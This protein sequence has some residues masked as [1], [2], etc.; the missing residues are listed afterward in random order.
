MWCIPT[1]LNKYLYCILLT[2]WKVKWLVYAMESLCL[3][4]LSTLCNFYTIFILFCYFNRTS[5]PKINFHL[6]GP[7]KHE[8]VLITHFFHSLWFGI[9]LW[10]VLFVV[11]PYPHK[12]FHYQCFNPFTSLNVFFIF[13]KWHYAI[14]KKLILQC[15]I[16]KWLMKC[17]AVDWEGWGGAGVSKGNGALKNYLQ[18]PR[19]WHLTYW[20]VF[21]NKYFHLDN[22]KSNNHYNFLKCDWCISFFIFH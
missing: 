12:H 9:F 19:W 6:H 4:W 17:I 18:H 21:C 7:G 14:L 2:F 10:S 1:H 16:K 3:V 11:V 15:D 13:I 8:W 22:F 5:I 20:C